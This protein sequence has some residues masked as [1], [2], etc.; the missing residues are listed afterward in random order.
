MGGR[1]EE[2]S[3]ESRISCSDIMLNFRLSQKLKLLRYGKF[4]HL[5]NTSNKVHKVQSIQIEK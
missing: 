3:I 2:T 4:N 5:T 1:V